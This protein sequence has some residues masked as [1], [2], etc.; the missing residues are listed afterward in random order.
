[1][2]FDKDFKEAI[3]HLPSSEKDKLIFRLLKKDI[4]LANRLYFELL[5]NKTVDDRRAEMEEKVRDKISRATDSYWT[6]GYL[7]MDMRY[8]SGEIT[9]HVYITKDKYGEASLNLLMLN[10]MLSNNNHKI[11]ETTPDKARKICVYI[12]ARAFKILIIIK[13]L[14]E[15]YFIDFKDDLV[16]LGELM[17]QNDYIMRNA[18]QNGFDVNWLLLSEIPENI[19]QI[20]KDIRANGFLK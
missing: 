20:H 1:M 8:L 12:I 4:A 14:H 18:I 7:K 9:E 2:T 10:E 11:L 3:S 16:L 19:V 5:D 6:L 15:D 17:G 13:K